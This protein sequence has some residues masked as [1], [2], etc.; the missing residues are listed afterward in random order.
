MN[1]RNLSYRFLTVVT[2]LALL[3]LLPSSPSLQ[4]QRKPPPAPTTILPRWAEFDGSM[5]DGQADEETLASQQEVDVDWVTFDV[6]SGTTYL[7]EAQIPADSPADVVMERYDQCGGLPEGGQ[8]YDFSPGIRLEFEASASGPL[9]L[10]LIN[11]KP[12]VFGPEI[13]YHLSVRALND[14]ATPG[15]LVLV[16]GRLK[17]DDPVQDNIHNVTPISLK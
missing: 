11:N 8:G 13:S 16:A 5:P 17:E 7:I 10:K 4:A 1:S 2:L 14:E 9:Y 6:I 12:S 15:A 3:S